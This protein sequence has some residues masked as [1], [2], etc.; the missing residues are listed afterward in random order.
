MPTVIAFGEA[1]VDLTALERG[2]SL[3]EASGFNKAAG[4]APA[5]VAVG[6]SLLGVSS[7]FV[8]KVGEDPFGRFLAETLRSRGVDISGLIFSGEARTGLA[9]IALQQDGER[10]FTF[11]RHP[12]ADLYYRPGDIDP[13]LLDEARIFHFGSLS[14]SREPS[15]SATWKWLE[16]AQERGLK[17]SFD[18]NLRLDLWPNPET[19]RTVI[20]QTAGRADWIKLSADEFRFLTGEEPDWNSPDQVRETARD[21]FSEAPELLVIT[22]GRSGCLALTPDLE[23]FQPGYRVKTVDTTGAGDAFTAGLLAELAAH[24]EWD[25][26]PVPLESA[27]RT[28][29]AAGALTTTGSGVIPSLPGRGDVEELL[30]G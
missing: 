7:G 27:L 24:P 22:L 16:T 29:N 18:P 19:A 30:S 17:I 11:Y 25:L 14:L 4:G 1:L 15:A 12:S 23:L 3:A 26:G 28:A 8:G 13:A 2:V 21:L 6:V 5:N 10:E 20:L 9:F